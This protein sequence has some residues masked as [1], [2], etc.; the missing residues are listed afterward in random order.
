MKKIIF[1]WIAL[2]LSTVNFTSCSPDKTEE[3]NSA[4]IKGNN[5]WGNVGV[6]YRPDGR[7]FVFLVKYDYEYKYY[8][9]TYALEVTGTNYPKNSRICE[10]NL[11]DKMVLRGQH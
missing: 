11:I 6:E 3:P 2:S 7:I 1:L 10:D 9:S 5:C 8:G 4:W